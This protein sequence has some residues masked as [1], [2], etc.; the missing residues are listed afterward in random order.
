[1]SLATTAG[2]PSSSGIDG[3]CGCGG[4][5]GC[6]TSEFTR[7]RYAYGLRLGAVELSDEQSYLVGK[8]RFHNARCHGAGVLCGLKVDRFHF[9]QG[10]TSPSTVLRV[11]RG[12]ALDCCG[13]EV[14]VPVAI[15]GDGG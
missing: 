8:H 4:G 10:S 14:L 2:S 9:P 5:C 6:V 12:A 15:S 13:R 11:T 7:L 1:M 3:D